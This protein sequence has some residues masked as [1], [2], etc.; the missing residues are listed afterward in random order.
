MPRLKW[1]LFGTAAVL[2]LAA[3]PAFA[4][5]TATDSSVQ[6]ETEAPPPAAQSGLRLENVLVTA[7]K[8]EEDIQDVTAAITALSEDTL[9]RL[10]I[11]DIDNLQYQVPGLNS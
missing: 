11:Q 2:S 4:D 5:E 6:T 1:S 10:G 3:M 8:R 7:Q 9:D